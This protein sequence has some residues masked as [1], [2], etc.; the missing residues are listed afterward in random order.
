M[1]EALSEETRRFIS[2][3]VLDGRGTPADLL[4]APYTFINNQLAT[5]YRF[6]PVAGTDYAQVDRPA[7]WGVGLLAQGSLLAIEAHSLTTSPD[8]ARLP[9]AHAAA[10]RDGA[11]AARGGRPA[12]RA[13]RGRDHPPALRDAARQRRLLPGLPP[14]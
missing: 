8:Q 11:A 2:G 12:A 4:T 7:G 14:A 9:G 10:V 3:V 6:A 13:H 5:Y 1:Q